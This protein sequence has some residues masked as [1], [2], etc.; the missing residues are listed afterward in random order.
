MNLWEAANLLQNHQDTV[1]LIAARDFSSDPGMH[2]WTLTL[3]PS[4]FLHI[5]TPGKFLSGP[6][7]WVE[8]EVAVLSEI[9][10]TTNPA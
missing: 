3:L 8:P 1:L 9:R 5:S 2:F 7:T 10:Q 4:Y 6:T